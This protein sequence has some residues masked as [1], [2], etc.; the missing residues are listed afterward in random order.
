M[1]TVKLSP[2]MLERAARA[3]ETWPVDPQWPCAGR[4]TRLARGRKVG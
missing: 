1:D 2:T 4:W 3:A